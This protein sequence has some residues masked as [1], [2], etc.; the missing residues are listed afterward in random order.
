[1]SDKQTPVNDL[2]TKTLEVKNHLLL[3][4]KPFTIASNEPAKEG[5][6]PTRYT[7]SYDI[8]GGYIR[9][10]ALEFQDGPIPE[11]GWNGLIDEAL[12]VVLIDRLKHW[13]AGPFANEANA[14]VLLALEESM[15]WRVNRTLERKARN[16]EGT[17]AV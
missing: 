15:L 9:S 10:H 1:M 11:K 8:G 7:V 5:L 17:H 13:Q 12:T 3:L 6:A 14:R 2:S 16:V 4:E